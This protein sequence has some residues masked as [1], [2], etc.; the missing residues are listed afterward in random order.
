MHTITHSILLLGCTKEKNGPAYIKTYQPILNLSVPASLLEPV[1]SKGHTCICFYHKPVWR[2]ILL[3]Y[4]WP[5]IR[6][7]FTL[8]TH[9]WVCCYCC[10]VCVNKIMTQANPE[11]SERSTQQFTNTEMWNERYS[12]AVWRSVNVFLMGSAHGMFLTSC[13]SMTTSCSLFNIN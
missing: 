11:S 13:W 9:L 7:V 4:S 8:K 2:I 10:C 3:F 5:Q 1:S 12:E 6:A